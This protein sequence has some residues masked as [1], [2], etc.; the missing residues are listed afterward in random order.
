MRGP[1]AGPIASSQAAERAHT[2]AGFTPVSAAK[3]SPVARLARVSARRLEEIAAA[4][5]EQDWKILNFVSVAAC[6]RPTAHK[7]CVSR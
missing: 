4:M 5:S 3:D 6:Q 7:R 2:Q 1:V